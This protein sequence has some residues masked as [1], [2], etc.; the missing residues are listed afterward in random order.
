MRIAKIHIPKPHPKQQEIE[1]CE[2]SRIVIVAGRRAGKTTMSARK[3]VH[4]ANEGRKVLYAA[5]ISTQTDSFWEMCTAWLHPVIQTSLITKNETR[6]TLTFNH[7]SGKIQAVTAFKPDHVRGTYAD[8]LILDEYAYQNP[9]IWTKVGAPMLLDNDGDVWF[10]SSP[11]KR[12]HFYHLYLGAEKQNWARFHFTSLD[13][14]H[15]SEAALDEMIV[16]MLQ[17]DYDQEILAKF[18]P[19]FG[20]VFRL[21]MEDFFPTS[22]WDTVVKEHKDHRIVAG[23]DWG[24]Q[25]DSTV[26]SIGCATCS[27]ELELDKFHRVDYP[28]QRDFIKLIYERFKEI[29]EIE[30]LAESNS[31]G[32][33]NIEQMVLDGVP[34]MEF[35]TTNSSKAQIVQSLRLAFEQRSWKW[36]DDEDAL[37]ELE[38][39]E[40][41]ITP[42]GAVAYG[43]PSGVHDDTVM[44]RMI[45][46]RQ[47]TI[48]TFTLL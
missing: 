2:A 41:Q 3:A 1:D 47:A 24:R 10:I 26:M 13:N 6:R 12:N 7:S 5:P 42:K 23:L 14:P 25:N 34:L 46:L 17:E 11:D 9:E 27:K 35:M 16:D 45:M 28:S 32:L 33:P 18:V 19:G 31:I 38:A 36:L 15:L 8:F 48:G 39:Y 30:I 40:M 4:L 22:E 37:Q 29:G 43:A 21:H 44:A 20:S